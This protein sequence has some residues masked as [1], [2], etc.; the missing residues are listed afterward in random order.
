MKGEAVRARDGT[1]RGRRKKG[2]KNQKM[3]RAK[4]RGRD[5][6]TEQNVTAMDVANRGQARSI[7]W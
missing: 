7:D 1:E 6:S 2:R 3:E 5:K 4:G